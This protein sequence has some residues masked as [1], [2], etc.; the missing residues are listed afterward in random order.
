MMFTG[1]VENIG[2]VKS[3]V[4]RGNY[5]EITISPQPMFDELQRGGSIAISGACLT[6]TKYDNK[7]FTVDASQETLKLT[8]VGG[9]KPGHQVNLERALRVD[10]RLGGHF[11]AG[12]VDCVARVLGVKDV[13][14]SRQLQI[15]LSDDYGDLVVNKGS[16]ALDGVSLTI[17]NVRQNSF[18]VNLIPETTGRTTLADLR[19]GELINIEF[20]L[21]GKYI[22]RFL[23]LRRRGGKL[24]LED[25]RNMGY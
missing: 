11:V 21:I 24:S 23:E 9:F 7:S 3:V 25:M 12:H 15:E 14:Q 19:T 18:E 10:S 8:T 2:I 4:P 22:L 17:I 13:G 16:I 20:D 6:V 5:R 1:L